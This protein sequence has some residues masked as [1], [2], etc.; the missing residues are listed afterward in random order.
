[1]HSRRS[2]LAALALLATATLAGAMLRWQAA[3]SP[4]WVDEL[5]T[6]W[7]VSGDLSDLELTVYH[8]IDPEVKQQLVSE[9]NF[10]VL[11]EVHR[12]SRQAFDAL[13]KM[14]ARKSV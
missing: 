2:Q 13:L 9:P 4:L 11:D 10:V 12:L 8:R 7:A 14:C 6:S 1:M 3:K 5:H